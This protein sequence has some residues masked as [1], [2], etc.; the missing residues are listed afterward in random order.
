MFINKS[1][2]RTQICFEVYKTYKQLLRK[3]LFANEAIKVHSAIL[4]YFKKISDTTNGMAA[5]EANYF[6]KHFLSI[7][8]VM[9]NVVV[10]FINESKSSDTD[11]LIFINTEWPSLNEFWHNFNKGTALDDQW[12][13]EMCKLQVSKQPCKFKLIYKMF[14]LACVIR[15]EVFQLKLPDYSSLPMFQQ[16]YAKYCKC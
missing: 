12:I 7:V 4:R 1:P 9:M 14:I 13:K 15:K 10:T 3:R 2:T 11:P 6:N 8:N 5:E 16:L